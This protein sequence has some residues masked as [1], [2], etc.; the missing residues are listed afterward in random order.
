MILTSEPFMRKAYENS[1]WFFSHRLS[2][3]LM[4]SSTPIFPSGAFSATSSALPGANTYFTTSACTA[5]N[6]AF[7]VSAVFFPVFVSRMSRLFSHG[8]LAML[9]TPRTTASSTTS[10]AAAAAAA[11]AAAVHTLLHGGQVDHDLDH[12]YPNLPL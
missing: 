4:P 6:R 2:Q 8:D 3:T 9:S 11:A 5:T 7:R 12:L 10:T 1:I